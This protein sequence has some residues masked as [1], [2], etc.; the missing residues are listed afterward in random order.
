MLDTTALPVDHRKYL[1]LFCEALTESA[2]KLDDG[3][4]ISHEEVVTQLNRDFLSYG[5]GIGID[6]GGRFKVGSYS[7]ILSFNA[8]VWNATSSIY[9]QYQA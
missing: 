5:C 3:T 8:Q 1:S 6:G 2:V 7:H 9:Q 4:V